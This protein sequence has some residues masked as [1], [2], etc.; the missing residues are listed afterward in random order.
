MGGMKGGDDEGVRG[1][2]CD[3]EL[4][5]EWKWRELKGSGLGCVID[6][7]GPKEC[8]E[9]NGDGVGREEQ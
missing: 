1:R 7:E 4:E 6:G 9:K 3:W 8:R 2:V 5:E